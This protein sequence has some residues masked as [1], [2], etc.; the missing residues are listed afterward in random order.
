MNANRRRVSRRNCFKAAG[1]SLSLPFLES[2]P[3][4]AQ[5]PKRSGKDAEVAYSDQPASSAARLVC[6]GVALGMYPGEWNPSQE[7]R[8]Y[9]APRLIEPLN[10][11]RNDFTLLSNIDHPGV[12]GGH[13]GTPAFLSGV[14]KPEFVGQAIVVRN[15]ITLDQFAAQHLGN[16]TRFSSLQLSA[17]ELGEFDALSWN[18]KGT[19]LPSQ[20]DPSK[21][22]NALFVPDAKDEATAMKLGQSVLDLIHED[23]TAFQREISRNDRDRMDQYM[24]SVRDVEKRIQRQLQWTEK[25]KPHAPPLAERP[26]TYHENLDLILELAAIALQTDS[27]RVVS[28]SLPGQGLPIETNNLRTANYHNLSHHGMAA[29]AVRDLIEVESMHSRSLAKFLKRLKSVRAGDG[30][31]LDHTQVLFGSGLGNASSHS[32]RDLPVLIA[33]GGYKHGQH[34]RLE[35]GTPLCNLFVTMLQRMGME[36]DS[37]AGSRGNANQWLGV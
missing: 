14:Y 10:E 5:K 11:L 33:G 26:T 4:H 1:V 24:S 7:G 17:A 23:A 32:N 12:G 2:L 29:D 30:T 20:S 21:V 15:Q 34:V 18:E 28:V 31:L 25:P 16:G 36:V 35:E 19:P 22:F 9:R 37:F 8:D 3:V 27:T 13:K 6:I